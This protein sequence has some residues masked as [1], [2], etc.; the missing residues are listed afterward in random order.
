VKLAA[1]SRD[2]HCG[3]MRDFVVSLLM[4]PC[5]SCSLRELAGELAE[6]QPKIVVQDS[7]ASRHHLNGHSFVSYVQARSPIISK[8]GAIAHLNK[9][10]PGCGGRLGLSNP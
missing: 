6:G 3:V 9:G 8:M 2:R 7:V 5:G 1:G 10:L 4:Y